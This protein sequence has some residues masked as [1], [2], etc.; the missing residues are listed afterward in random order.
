MFQPAAS[1]GQGVDDEQVAVKRKATEECAGRVDHASQ[2]GQQARHVG[3][4]GS[5]N[6]HLEACAALAKGVHAL[7]AHLHRPVHQRVVAS[8][9]KAMARAADRGQGRAHAPARWRFEVEQTGA[10]FLARH[11]KE[12]AGAAQEGT[13]LVE[14]RRAHT[15]FK[16]EDAIADLN[17]PAVAHDPPAQFVQPFTGNRAA[18]AGR[19]QVVDMAGK[20]P[21][22]VAA[23]R[24]R[25]KDQ[26][27]H[28]ALAQGRDLQGDVKFV[29]RRLGHGHPIAEGSGGR[30]SDNITRDLPSDTIS[31]CRPALSF[32][33]PSISILSSATSA[34]M[35]CPAAR[36]TR[37]G[38]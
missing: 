15:L 28:R 20:V 30:H 13:I 10:R 16:G 22:H 6:G 7:E 24:P 4:G 9:A 14:K 3:I 1:F 34:F 25:G 12:Q 2:V 23:R 37:S 17:R 18:V 36:R 19:L 27:Q 8:G 5:G 29:T 35:R 26:I 21:N 33:S 31:A 38:M 11:E 32:L